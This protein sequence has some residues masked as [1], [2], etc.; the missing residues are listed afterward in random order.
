MDVKRLDDDTMLQIL[1]CLDT[2]EDVARAGA[3]CRSW[4]RLVVDGRLWRRLCMIRFPELEV[5]RE[6]AEQSSGVDCTTV[7]LS[8]SRSEED[9]LRREHK[10]FCD[11]YY[12]LMRTSS[13]RSSYI[14][15]ALHASSTDNPNEEVIQTLYPHPKRLSSGSP[16]YWSSTGQKLET[17]PEFLTYRM[18]TPL[19]VVEE[20]KLRP[21]EAFFQYGSPI[22]SPKFVR[23][24]F[25]YQACRAPGGHSWSNPHPD[26]N[27]VWKYVSPMYPVE[28]ADSLQTFRLPRP[29]V[30]IGGIFQVELIGRVQKQSTDQL[31]YICICH[32][33]AQGRS[34]QRYDFEIKDP[35]SFVLKS[36][37]KP[38][39]EEKEE[40]EVEEFFRDEEDEEFFRRLRPELIVWGRPVF[41]DDDLEE[42]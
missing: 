2:D 36:L 38:I 22:Y 11:F 29:V 35:K 13:T 33:S 34:L 3:V 18:V 1:G 28:Q 9:I 31:Y 23:F 20:I 27:Y 24:Y 7:E 17:V 39:E 37:S 14:W 41:E 6:V 42:Y 15:N 32:V 5:F 25:G 10:V 4:H 21:F 40:E 30:C 19:C 26:G 8:K 16:S 12:S